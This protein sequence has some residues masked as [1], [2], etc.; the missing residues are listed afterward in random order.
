MTKT[1]EPGIVNPDKHRI[2]VQNL[3]ASYRR[4]LGSRPVLR[5]VTFG[6]RSGEVTAV[7]GPNGAGK[8]TLFRVLLGFMRP[9]SGDCLVGGLPPDEYRR[10]HGIGYLP[11]SAKLPRGWTGLDVLGRGADLAV[12]RRERRSEYSLALKR[13]ALD[14]RSLAK[15]VGK[16]SNGTQRRL[17]LACALIGDPDV[18]VLDEPFAGLDPP[19]RRALR[20]QMRAARARGAAVLLATHDLAE[21]ARLADRIVF[22]EGGCTKATKTLEPGDAVSVAGLER[23]FFGESDDAVP[24]PLS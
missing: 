8:T 10:R 15:E 5:G 14:R 22:L 4:F 7:V 24:G 1:P 16:C 19:A 6:A 20:H 12:G 17:W 18:V 13:A 21:A 23:E 9:D 3:V 2:R 11:E